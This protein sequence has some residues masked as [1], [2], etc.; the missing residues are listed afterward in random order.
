MQ[1]PLP[2]Y[3]RASDPVRVGGRTKDASFVRALL[4]RPL[5]PAKAPPAARAPSFASFASDVTCAPPGDAE[6]SAAEGRAMRR[7]L[8]HIWTE[9]PDSQSFSY[10]VPDDVSDA[11]TYDSDDTLEDRTPPPPRGPRHHS[12][13][14]PTTGRH[15]L[16]PGA[17]LSLPDHWGSRG[18]L[19]AALD[20]PRPPFSAAPPPAAP[21]RRK[22]TVAFS[23]SALVRE[24]YSAD[25]YE[26]GYPREEVLRMWEEGMA[27]LAADG[28]PR[29]GE[30][31][32]WG[33]GPVGTD[34]PSLWG[35][36]ESGLQWFRRKQ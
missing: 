15:V 5:P 29:N 9:T 7:T 1:E 27:A 2:V 26:R 21:P 14:S 6:P 19:G 35:Y 3:R 20:L 28:R 36:W 10:D 25:E 30:G 13:A 16:L 34:V 8:S 31:G 23:E 12:R 32:G 18:P 24:T 4:P 33:E 22:K 17:F 11:E